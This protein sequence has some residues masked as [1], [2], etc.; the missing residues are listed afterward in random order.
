MHLDTHIASLLERHDCV[1]VPDFGGFVANYAP[2]RINP[3][4]HRFDPPFRKISFNKLLVHNDGLLAAYVA[5]KENERYEEALSRVKDYVIYLKSELRDKKKIELEK[6]GILF[7]QND[8]TFR[9]E[10]MKDAKMFA[11]GF[12]LESFFSKRIERQPKFKVTVEPKSEKAAPV[13]PPKPKPEPKVIAIQ[14]EAEPKKETPKP[15]EPVEEPAPVER[16]EKKKRAYWPAAVAASIALPLV[17][18]AVWVALSTP[19]LSNRSHFRYADLNPLSERLYPEYITRS[20][21]ADLEAMDKMSA[22][23]INDSEDFMTVYS[24]NDPD[25]TL[26]VRLTEPKE[27]SLN[28]A[29]SELRYHIMGGCFSYPENAEGLVHKYRQWGSNASI[30]DTKGGLHRVSVASFATKKEAQQ[31]L[32]SYQN[33]IS[34]A[35]L[36]YK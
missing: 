9:F 16:E 14:P 30:I 34:G 11:E 31:A 20:S 19:L 22:A 8:G 7:Q 3:V 29:S 13:V 35:W 21:D 15:E 2:A 1:I 23:E 33:D 4:N 24:E 12:G 27:A 25:K 26:V 18:Y 36:L 17:G 10:Q 5:Q 32:A 6:V 28:L